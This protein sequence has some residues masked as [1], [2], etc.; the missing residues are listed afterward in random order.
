MGDRSVGVSS[1]TIKESKAS[2]VSAEIAELQRTIKPLRNAFKKIAASNL[3]FQAALERVFKLQVTGPGASA[4]VYTLLANRNQYTSVDSI[5]NAFDALCK[6]PVGKWQQECKDISDPGLVEGGRL[7]LEVCRCHFIQVLENKL[8]RER[9]AS[10]VALG[11]AVVE[12]KAGPGLA[13][14]ARIQNKL[15][16]LTE[17]ML[18]TDTR[19][20]QWIEKPCQSFREFKMDAG[21]ALQINGEKLYAD[22]KLLNAAI[23]KHRDGVK[24]AASQEVK[25]D[26]STVQSIQVES[27]R[28]AILN[29]AFDKL[30]K[31]E[32]VLSACRQKVNEQLSIA[33]PF[34]FQSIERDEDEH[35]K[36]PIPLLSLDQAAFDAEFE[37]SKEGCEIVSLVR[38]VEARKQHKIAAFEYEQLKISE[39]NARRKRLI[40]L[41]GQL[42][43]YSSSY[44]ELGKRDDFSKIYRNLNASVNLLLQEPLNKELTSEQQAELL[45]K[46]SVEISSL[47]Q[48][49]QEFYQRRNKI[50]EN[51][52]L[53]ERSS[54][55]AANLKLKKEAS[56]KRQEFYEAQKK[57]I[58]KELTPAFVEIQGV[59]DLDN[60]VKRARNLLEQKKAEL[61]AATLAQYQ[62]EYERIQRLSKDTLEAVSAKQKQLTTFVDKVHALCQQWG[63]LSDFSGLPDAIRQLHDGVVLEQSRLQE[64]V[65]ALEANQAALKFQVQF[66]QIN[67]EAKEETTRHY[68]AKALALHTLHN[69]ILAFKVGKELA[70]DNSLVLLEQAVVAAKA[71]AA[72]AHSAGWWNVILR[73]CQQ[74]GDAV[75]RQ[76]KATAADQSQTPAQKMAA[77]MALATDVVFAESCAQKSKLD[78]ECKAF[79]AATDP[80][81]TEL[82]DKPAEAIDVTYGRL[83]RCVASEKACAVE[84]DAGRA[85]ALVVHDAGRQA[86]SQSAPP[87]WSWVK[88]GLG[89]VFGGIGALL[90]WCHYQS[91]QAEYEQGNPPRQTGAQAGP[92]A[93]TVPSIAGSASAAAATPSVV[94]AS[95]VK[96]TSLPYAAF[97]QH[98]QLAVPGTFP[99]FEAEQAAM[100]T[101][102]IRE[103]KTSNKSGDPQLASSQGHPQ[104]ANSQGRAS[105]DGIF[106]SVSRSSAGS[107]LTEP[108][109]STSER[110]S[111]LVSC[112]VPPG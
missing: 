13:Y 69:A 40:G 65:L 88:F 104:L 25:V 96:K 16:A 103:A 109:L 32:T 54:I 23:E 12:A 9:A 29:R 97:M 30:Q 94:T 49:L 31:R 93:V 21:F 67:K 48:A 72:K 68:A 90:Y 70:A 14:E 100:R 52:R 17:Q 102:A 111:A 107:G 91:Q 6:A 82:R 58:S 110:S 75:D 57:N 11:E 1:D 10:P 28:L 56:S 78:A 112:S 26:L 84:V 27:N 20:K 15:L 89:L 41:Q 19:I 77:V 34:Y 42:I 36:Q 101:A 7:L 98:P 35:K 2:V 87:Q 39:V 43:A 33:C 76:I 80:F 64:Q 71:N 47:E 83:Q 51:L 63:G 50:R 106:G 8:A 18:T 73:D 5:N 45:E 37:Q 60:I 61:V 44:I 85:P 24:E 95:A 3:A 62:P 53:S 105:V 38:V 92:G 99:Q 66:D 79:S 46:H 81:L 74:C 22:L 108:L 55:A 4:V 59:I 86:K